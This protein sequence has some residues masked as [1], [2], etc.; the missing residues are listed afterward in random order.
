MYRGQA[1]TGILHFGDAAMERNSHEDKV[2]SSTG[3]SQQRTCDRQQRESG[4]FKYRNYVKTQTIHFVFRFNVFWLA[5]ETHHPGATCKLLSVPKAHTFARPLCRKT[6]L[7]SK[8][9]GGNAAAS[10]NAK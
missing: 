8:G 2:Y 10:A 3:H 5:D 7:H 9:Y 6:L 4:T 1:L